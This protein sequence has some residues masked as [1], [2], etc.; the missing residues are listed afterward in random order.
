MPPLAVSVIIC[1]F[2]GARQV[3][4][5]LDSLLALEFDD[6]EIVLIDDGSSDD[7]PRLLEE[8]RAAHPDRQIVFIRNPRNLGLSAARN[9]GI[10]AARGAL[11]A[12]TN[13]DCVA[14]PGWLAALVKAFDDPAVVAASGVVHDEPPRTWAESAYVGTLRIGQ[15]AVQGR[16]LVGNNLAF[17]R[18]TLLRYPFDEALTYYCDED[19]LAWR[20]QVAGLRV[21]F[22]ADAIV[23]HD[24]PMSLGRYMRM[25]RWQGEGSARLWYKHGIY[26]G[27]DLLFLVGAVLTLPLGLIDV[28]LLAIPALGFFLQAAALGY[29]ER[30]FKGKGLGQTLKVLPLTYLFTLVKAISVTRTYLRMLFGKEPAIRTSKQQWFGGQL[31]PKTLSTN[32]IAANR[33]RTARSR[34]PCTGWHDLADARSG[35]SA[36][37]EGSRDDFSR[38]EVILTVERPVRARRGTALRS[39]AS[40]VGPENSPRA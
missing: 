6:F 30:V 33:F 3:Q 10:N 13:Q 31:N 22:V 32:E 25:A 21:A 8:F 40:R 36:A 28:R 14:A 12:F 27:R 20:L 37:D 11:I 2:N 19:D 24:H 9:V 15:G 29:N 7:S 17:R 5:C 18:E 34:S 23:Y 35:E 4:G 16:S 26:L 38:A 1:V 39:R